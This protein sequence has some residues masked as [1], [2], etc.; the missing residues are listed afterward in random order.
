M[1]FVYQRSSIIFRFKHPNIW[2]DNASTCLLSNRLWWW[3]LL[4][5]VFCTNLLLP[6]LECIEIAPVV[7]RDELK[8]FPS[9]TC[10]NMSEHVYRVA[11]WCSHVGCDQ[12]G[13]CTVTTWMGNCLVTGKPYRDV[14][15][16]QPPTSTQLPITPG[17]VIEIE[18]QPVFWLG[19]GGVCS[20]V[21]VGWRVTLWSHRTSD[22]P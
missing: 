19:L 3:S 1:F 8:W 6:M 16:T 21:S 9:R 10:L 13:C 2:R 12:R 17:W 14:P 20:L 11:A 5:F 4:V 7:S 18:Y 22:A 15:T